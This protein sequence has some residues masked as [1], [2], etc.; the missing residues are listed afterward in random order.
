MHGDIGNFLTQMLIVLGGATVLSV[1]FYRLRLPSILAFLLVGFLCG[2]TGFKII[3]KPEELHQL[4]ELGLTF[5]LF[6][7]GLEFSIPK[8]MALRNTVF[9]LGGA[10]VV[11]C[12]AVFFAAF[13]WWGLPWETSLIV[14]GGL[15]LS[16]T[17]IVSRELIQRGQLHYRHGQIAIGVL[18]FQDLVAIGL[19]I[20]VPLLAGTGEMASIKDTALSLVKSVG[21]LVCF[22][23]VA[24][25]VLPFLLSEVARSRSDELL[26]L[27][28]LVI[29]LV[30]GVM[31]S[32]I[33]LSMEL[34]AFLAGMM[35]GD[36]RFRHQLETDVRPLRD[37]LLGLFFISIGMLVDT[38]M[39]QE[40]WKRIILCGLLLLAFKSAIIAGVAKF[41]GESWR[42]ALPAGLILAQG[43]EF[44]F[45]LLSLAARDNLVEPDVA[46]FLIAV[47]IVSMGLTP[48]LI[49][50][51]EVW[52]DILINKFGQQKKSEEIFESTLDAESKQGHVIILG[53]GRV[54]QIFARFL[55]QVNIEYIALETDTVRIAEAVSAGEPVFYGD[56]TRRDILKSA[57]VEKASLL[58]I[59]FDDAVQAAHIA[60]VVKELN[61]SLKI[62]VRTRDDSSLD[63]LLSSGATEIVPEIL[64]ASLTLVS[65]A[66]LLLGL[67]SRKI[68][69]LIDESRRD[70]YRI[71]HGFYHGERTGLINEHADVLHAVRLT[72][73]AWVNGKK[74]A[75]LSFP[76][77][78]NSIAGIKRDDITIDG[79]AIEASVLV[80][81]DIVLLQGTLDQ[82][83][84]CEMYLLTGRR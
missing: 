44:L 46:S 18:L 48:V 13:Y 30:A 75:H 69:T 63:E 1:I 19:L 77:A 20:A 60:R 68:H 29:V 45:A 51:A 57:G 6:V 58:V 32:S 67:P 50:Y 71:L 73:N 33:G 40:Y 59:S 41:L 81:D 14:A 38:E 84:M 78:K 55:K 8:L 62:L 2:P 61:P 47:T 82:V 52:T 34:G 72:K 25:Y 43:G 23:L 64:E 39:L 12:S 74:V 10:Q 7:L 3:A 70:R 9:R 24:R 15:A 27:S 53:F 28:A 49:R 35:L 26:V 66:L 83:D 56:T 22:Y 80:A 37:I 17:A 65:H 16:S 54:A 4:A 5:L 42:A 21:L 76:G 36:S 11:V 79:E 31:T